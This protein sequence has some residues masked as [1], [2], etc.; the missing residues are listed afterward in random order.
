M[1]RHREQTISDR[2]KSRLVGSKFRW[3]NER[4][5][6]NSGKDSFEMFKQNENLFHE[7]HKGFQEQT[8]HWPENPLNVII[9][10][11]EK[12]FGSASCETH[13]N[14]CDMGCGEAR[15][16]QALTKFTNLSIYSYDLVSCNKFVTTCEMRN[17][18]LENETMDSVIYCL[19]LMGTDWFD[20]LKEGIRVLKTGGI[21]YLAEV[22]SRIE[23]IDSF[24]RKIHTL[25]LKCI[26]RNVQNTHFILLTFRKD[27]NVVDRISSTDSA[28][29]LLK[30]CLYKKR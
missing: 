20:C 23:S 17:I 29:R 5:Y 26:Q 10:N 1:K 24:I 8:K 21:L 30:P 2:I 6:S 27:G 11:I 4:L 7:Y 19:S 3:I 12:K 16:A 9:K 15:L 28:K 25:G 18:P 14:I 22:T 13:F